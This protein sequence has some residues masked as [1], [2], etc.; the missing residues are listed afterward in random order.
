VL[1]LHRAGNGAAGVVVVADGRAEDGQDGVA[2]ELVD[3]A[4]VAQ[5]HVGH[6]RQVV[7]EDGHDL[8]RLE[9]FA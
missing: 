7:V 6:G 4:A 9:R 8:A 3:G 2:D 5:D 1:H